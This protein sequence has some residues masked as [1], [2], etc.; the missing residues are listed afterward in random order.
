MESNKCEDNNATKYGN[1]VKAY[2]PKGLKHLGWVVENSK[3]QSF[4]IMILQ[5]VRCISSNLQG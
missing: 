3:A 1:D 4:R 5:D 2:H